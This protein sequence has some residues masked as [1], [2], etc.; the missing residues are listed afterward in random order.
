MDNIEA[1][2]FSFFQNF[3][4]NDLNT[5]GDN[6][7]NVIGQKMN[8]FNI[9]KPFNGRSLSFEEKRFIY[10]VGFVIVKNAIPPK[11]YKPT[12]W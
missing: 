3:M 10:D 4:G 1:K 5:I 2:D 7:M 6:I 11:I 12:S 8:G 9:K